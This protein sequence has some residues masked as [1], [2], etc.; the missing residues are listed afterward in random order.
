MKTY[1]IIGKWKYK[2]RDNEKEDSKVLEFLSEDDMIKLQVLFEDGQTFK[3]ENLKPNILSDPDQNIKTWFFYHTWLSKK[4]DKYF[5]FES[6]FIDNP[7]HM[8]DSFVNVQEYSFKDE[9]TLEQ[10]LK[11]FRLDARENTWI[12]FE[13]LDTLYRVN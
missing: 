4:G 9:N 3:P 1:D 5:S 6:R 11:G 13:Q 8:N 12:A 7:N 2:S 10:T